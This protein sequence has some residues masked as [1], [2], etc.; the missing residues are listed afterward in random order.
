MFLAVPKACSTDGNW[1]L[2]E[3]S[4]FGTSVVILVNLECFPS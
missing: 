4:L 3:S 1:G 2:L